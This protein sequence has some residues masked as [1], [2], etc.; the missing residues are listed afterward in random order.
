MTSSRQNTVTDDV[1][2]RKVES[3]KDPLDKLIVK[4]GNPHR[5]LRQDCI[6]GKVSSDELHKTLRGKLLK[7][8][9]KMNKQ[10]Y[11]PEPTIRKEKKLSKVEIE[12]I[13]RGWGEACN[14]VDCANANNKHWLGI[15]L[16]DIV[17]GK[18]EAEQ[19]KGE[20]IEELLSLSLIHI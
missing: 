5:Q 12:S 8:V 9:Y 7:S 2:Q 6:D 19:G 13:M 10:P 18:L 1:E 15:L 14:K 16:K 4:K 11:P 20:E 17:E 3:I